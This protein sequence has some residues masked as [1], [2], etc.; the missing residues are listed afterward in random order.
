MTNGPFAE[1]RVSGDDGTYA[2]M[3]ETIA[4]RSVT[5]HIDGRSTA[6]FG[7]LERIVLYVGRVGGAETPLVLAE[8][9]GL[10]RRLTHRLAVDGPCYV[11]VEAEAVC[12][13]KTTYALTNPIWIHPPDA[14]WPDLP[15]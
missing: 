10:E 8:H 11:R 4:E 6:E 7:P 3:G 5:V 1:L 13:G 14:R 15:A 2:D 9:V 12:R